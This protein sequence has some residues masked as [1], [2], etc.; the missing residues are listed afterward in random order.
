[1]SVTT[2]KILV[3][4]TTQEIVPT[5][6]VRRDVL[7]HAKQACHIGGT[8]VTFGQGYLMDNGDKIRMTVFEGD[9][10]WAVTEAGTGD[11]YVL[12]SAQT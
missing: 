7:I 2:K 10:V 5:D 1:M 3:T 8:G 9:V 6:N 12:I 11:L 4:T